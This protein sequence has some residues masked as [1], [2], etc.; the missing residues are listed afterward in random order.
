M[1]A[2]AIPA[3]AVSL[4]SRVR[5]VFSQ[6]CLDRE[7]PR[8]RDNDLCTQSAQLCFQFRQFIHIDLHYRGFVLT[9]RS[10]RPS[11]VSTRA[12]SALDRLKVAV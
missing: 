7:H 9:F 3:A 2:L 1:V 5:E 4:C 8:F 10:F 11:S 6:K 12:S